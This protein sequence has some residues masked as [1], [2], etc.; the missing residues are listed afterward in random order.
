MVPDSSLLPNWS[1]ASFGASTDQSPNETAAL[2]SH[3]DH[4]RG[5][6][7]LWN[8]VHFVARQVH[9]FAAA[10]LITSLLVAGFLLLG[11]SALVG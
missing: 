9:G 11:V 1:T 6:H 5:S 10:R 7:G 2:G 3:L 4:C 8:A